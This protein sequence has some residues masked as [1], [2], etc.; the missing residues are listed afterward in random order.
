MIIKVFCWEMSSFCFWGYLYCAIGD[1]NNRL[2]LLTLPSATVL[3]GLLKSWFNP[4][5]TF[6]TQK[7]PILQ[8]IVST[9]IQH[10]LWVITDITV[11]GSNPHHTIVWLHLCSRRSTSKLR[12]YRMTTEWM[13]LVLYPEENWKRTLTVASSSHC[14]R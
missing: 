4:N 10:F 6:S 5:Q 13:C 14:Y 3:V 11:F 8:I 9:A 7:H 12:W 2:F 1:C